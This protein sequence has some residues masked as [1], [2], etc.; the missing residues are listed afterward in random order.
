MLRICFPVIGAKK[1]DP[2]LLME[3]HALK[4][5]APGLYFNR[6]LV[7]FKNLETKVAQT[8]RPLC[9]N[10]ALNMVPYGANAT[11]EEL[12]GDSMYG[13][14]SLVAK[15]DCD[16]DRCDLLVAISMTPPE[17]SGASKIEE[18]LQICQELSAR[19]LILKSGDEKDIPG[20]MT[21]PLEKASLPAEDAEFQVW[22]AGKDWQEQ[23]ARLFGLVERREEVVAP[24]QPEEPGP[25]FYELYLAALFPE[26]SAEKH[27]F[28][29]I[30]QQAGA[31]YNRP[32]REKTFAHKALFS[33]DEA[34]TPN[35]LFGGNGK[36]QPHVIL[37]GPTSTGKTAVAHAFLLNALMSGKKAVY[38]S[39]TR[40]LV[41][42]VYE[43]FLKLF[44]S[45][46]AAAHAEE[47]SGILFDQLFPGVL[48]RDLVCSTGERNEQDGQILRS[49]YRII[50][51][52]YE[53][54]NIFMNLML[55]NPED[56]TPALV[57]ID[58]LHMLLNEERGGILDMF[59]AKTQDMKKGP[60]RIVGITTENDGAAIL[61]NFLSPPSVPT[62]RRKDREVI[63]LE[64]PERP[65]PVT[66]YLQL[67]DRREKIME[68][69]SS[70]VPTLSREA[71]GAILN[72]LLGPGQQPSVTAFSQEPRHSG[73]TESG[74][75][76][77]EYGANE[78]NFENLLKD[79]EHKKVLV[80]FKSI[81]TI[82]NVLQKLVTA[83]LKDSAVPWEEEV[84][85]EKFK[86]S[87]S[88]CPVDTLKKIHAQ[89]KSSF[90]T[91]EER[92]NL[93]RG[94]QAGIFVYFS[95][96]DYWL[97]EAMAEAFKEKFDKKQLLL[98]TN[99][100]AY[101]VNLPADAVWLTSIRD[102]ND[103]LISSNEFF[104]ILG[105]AG[106]LGKSAE[107]VTPCAY[108][109]PCADSAVR[110]SF[111]DDL[112]DALR[113]YGD[114]KD[115]FNVQTISI[116]DLDKVYDD[117]LNQLSDV[118]DATFRSVLDAL[119]FVNKKNEIEEIG[120]TSPYHVR[121]HFH[122]S[123]FG[124]RTIRER[125]D[126][127]AFDEFLETVY[128]VISDASSFSENKLVNK[129]KDASGKATFA[130]TE[131]ASALIDTG[132]KWKAIEPMTAWLQTIMP[133][134]SRLP[135][136]LIL[137]GIL[138]VQELW[139]VVRRF[140]QQ[141]RKMDIVAISEDSREF[142]ERSL[143]AEIDRLGAKV[144]TTRILELIDR[145]LENN[146]QHLQLRDKRQ[147]GSSL[148]PEARRNSF[149]RLLAAFLRWARGANA[150]EIKELAAPV[151][152]RQDFSRGFSQ[153]YGDKASWL[154]VLCLRFFSKTK[155]R[156]LDT[157]HESTLQN[158]ALRMRYGVPQECVP[159]M[160]LGKERQ[161]RSDIMRYREEYGITP[162][163]VLQN[164]YEA[165]AKMWEAPQQHRSKRGQSAPLG[166]YNTLQ[167]NAESY[168]C[169]EAKEFCDILAL[170]S[171][172]A[173]EH[174]KAIKNYF[175][176]PKNFTHEALLPLLRNLV[177][178]DFSVDIRPSKGLT[179]KER[180]SHGTPLFLEVLDA[181][182][183]ASSQSGSLPNHLSELRNKTLERL[184]TWHPWKRNAQAG[185]PHP[186]ISL[187]ATVFLLRMLEESRHLEDVHD[188]LSRQKNAKEYIFRIQELISTGENGIRDLRNSMAGAILQGAL[189]LAE[190]VFDESDQEGN[191]R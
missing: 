96:M 16:Q 132:T 141:S 144:E 56:K 147:R 118:Q 113:Y 52:V 191:E 80:I 73:A 12:W 69:T 79:T 188:W 100:L 33:D 23:L 34:Y 83:R 18:K 30:F 103:T 123:V 72:R 170:G 190:P 187:I 136:E 26:E 28:A 108:V 138:S 180:H 14:A 25:Q 172:I 5:M 40:A 2:N 81:E 177:H 7:D 184:C 29:K 137:V 163:I 176:N 46:R 97:R 182:A 48:E 42:E 6:D 124:W 169:R 160:G 8:L 87:E 19:C 76:A 139:D 70:E 150:N 131:L 41:Y 116:T 93:W 74:A 53:K 99:A 185:P 165:Y 36:T 152:G 140:D 98:A 179:I 166:I 178:K 4:D 1:E 121:R 186:T 32:L 134:A 107:G 133:L 39:P 68:L 35:M 164:S 11:S 65:V 167:E 21:M 101:G 143:T 183:E 162:Q 51:S 9:E 159:F 142:A 75:Q 173:P 38:I 55:E 61:T 117:T 127:A 175:E 135:V 67:G 91:D 153:A 158:L 129:G 88:L 3:I 66:H 77:S 114:R 148:S 155:S 128:T 62:M 146:C 110:D 37:C 17:C 168:Y 78:F 60:A 106:R 112:G 181:S 22:L 10:V 13:A 95:P 126:R 31:P 122:H 94:A 63:R 149:Y 120:G 130:C 64:L 57:V 43:E 157:R 44:R 58:E 111:K 90:V 24:P 104:N 59:I 125:E 50:F 92:E 145:F 109:L 174:W 189:Q 105:R 156:L 119:R 151:K 86:K 84:D 71:R 27:V 115:D 49:D 45:M 82:Y 15:Y 89:L 47:E 171:A 85:W 161:K 54:A 102:V 20:A 154:C